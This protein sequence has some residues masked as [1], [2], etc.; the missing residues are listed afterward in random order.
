MVFGVATQVVEDALLPEALHGV[1]VLDL[2]TQKL[3]V[4]CRPFSLVNM[5]SKTKFWAG[6]VGGGQ[7]SGEGLAEV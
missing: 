5:M 4:G 6:E 7:K 1:P 2:K 3:R